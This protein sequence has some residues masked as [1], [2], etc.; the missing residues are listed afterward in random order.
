MSLAVS[1]KFGLVLISEKV[2][3][4]P[5]S[6]GPSRL[7]DLPTE[8]QLEI[9]QLVVIQPKALSLNLKFH[10]CVVPHDQGSRSCPRCTPH[11][12]CFPPALARVSR[13]TRHDA[14]KMFYSQNKFKV[15][16][17]DIDTVGLTKWLEHVGPEYRCL[18]RMRIT[19]RRPHRGHLLMWTML[20]QF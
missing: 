6:G 15:S 12:R 16:L 8:L 9:F 1:S 10:H 18:V 19:T 20:Q 4:T 7:L 11:S 13:S 3:I 5:P 2:V 14:L 17:R